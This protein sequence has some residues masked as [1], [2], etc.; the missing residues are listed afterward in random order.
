LQAECGK[1]RNRE[2]NHTCSQQH[3]VPLLND[4]V[5]GTNESWPSR[6]ETV[7]VIAE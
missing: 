3:L 4:H 1:G 5:S 6:V 7:T 2:K